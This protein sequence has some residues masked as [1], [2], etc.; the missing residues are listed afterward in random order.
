MHPPHSRDKGLGNELRAPCREASDKPAVFGLGGLSPSS[1]FEKLELGKFDLNALNVAMKGRC[2][3]MRSYTSLKNIESEGNLEV[4]ADWHALLCAILMQLT[5]ALSRT[6]LKSS[7]IVPPN[8]D[9]AEGIVKSFTEDEL[10]EWKVGVRSGLIKNDWAA[11]ITHRTY[12]SDN[13]SVG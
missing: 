4:E 11:L 12:I 1:S 2:E 10:E 5:C 9:A 13:L 8:L 3:R 7:I 6:N